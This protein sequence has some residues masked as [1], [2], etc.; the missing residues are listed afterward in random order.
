MARPKNS[1]LEG[2]GEALKAWPLVEKLFLRLP[3]PP[4][5]HNFKKKSRGTFVFNRFCDIVT[6]GGMLH[7]S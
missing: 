2:E 5:P 6:G 7:D 3:P 1:K 4:P